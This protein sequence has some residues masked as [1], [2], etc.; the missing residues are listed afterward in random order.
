MTMCG[1]LAALEPEQLLPFLASSRCATLKPQCIGCQPFNDEAR[2]IRTTAG[3]A[4]CDR[5]APV[6]FAIRNRA[7]LWRCGRRA[8]GSA[9]V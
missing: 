8:G 4:G 5:P 2:T 6:R 7:D 9:H 1:A 3:M